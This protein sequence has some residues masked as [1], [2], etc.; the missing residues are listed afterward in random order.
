MI[1]QEDI[2]SIRFSKEHY[3]QQSCLLNKGT[4]LVEYFENCIPFDFPLENIL[5]NMAIESIINKGIH[6]K[7][8][9]RVC[10]DIC[11]TYGM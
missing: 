1:L 8:Y 2:K 3:L 6:R 7:I 5:K 11:L 9:S 4:D 10:E